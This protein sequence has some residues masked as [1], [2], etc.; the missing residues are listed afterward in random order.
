MLIFNEKAFGELLTEAVTT[1]I[2]SGRPLL[3]WASEPCYEKL[4]IKPSRYSDCQRIVV[5]ACMY[6]QS[7]NLAWSIKATNVKLRTIAGL[8][9][10]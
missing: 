5:H 4:K 8:E 6:I 9:A 2:M 1:Q 10:R 3:S 7:R